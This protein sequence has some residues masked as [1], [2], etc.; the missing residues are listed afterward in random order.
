MSSLSDKVIARFLG[1]FPKASQPAID[2]LRAIIDEEGAKLL[3]ERKRAKIVDGAEEVYQAY[4]RHEGGVDALAKIS[5]AIEKDGL[6]MVL[7]KTKEYA[8]AVAQWPRLYRYSSEGRD[9][10]PM[11]ATWFFQRRYLDDSRAWVRTGGKPAPEVKQTLPEPKDW[12]KAVPEFIRVNE[13]W[14]RL[15]PDDQTFITRICETGSGFAG[16]PQQIEEE[17]RLRKV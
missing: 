8:A 4:P 1:E 7:S 10:V 3:K 12:Q 14:N 6:D 13:P 5:A 17:T 15:S 2:R 16:L 9:M 11:P